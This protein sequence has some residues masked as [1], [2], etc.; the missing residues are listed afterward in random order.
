MY[1]FLNHKLE[2]QDTDRVAAGVYDQQFD[3]EHGSQY[4]HYF[5][6]TALEQQT[7]RA[8]QLLA[9]RKSVDFTKNLCVI[10]RPQITLIC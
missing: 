8:K 3:S 2:F 6:Q 4:L 9:L 7:V 1:N 5:L 10:A